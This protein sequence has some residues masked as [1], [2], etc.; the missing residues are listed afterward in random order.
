MYTDIG[1]PRHRLS[2]AFFNTFDMERICID[3]V[4]F[5]VYDQY[6]SRGNHT[7]DT[8]LR[9]RFI[10]NVKNSRIKRGRNEQVL[11]KENKYSSWELKLRGSRT[12]LFHVNVIH[13]LQEIHDIRP[14]GVIYDDNY[15]PV[16]FKKI[17]VLDYIRALRRF[18]S[19]AMDLYRTLVKKYWGVDL[20]NIMYKLTAVELP[21][22]IYPA[23]VEDIA[24]GMYARG[25]SFSKYNTQSGTL[26]LNDVKCDNMMSV[27]R[28]YD[29][30]FKID[31]SEISP[32]V[33]NIVYVNGVNSGKNENKIQIKLYQKTFGLLRIEFTIY[34]DDALSIFNFNE[35]DETIAE[36]L[37]LF[38]HNGLFENDITPTRYDRSLDDIVRFLAVAVKEPED[39]IYFLRNC[40]VFEANRANKDLRARLVH[41]GLLLR[42]TDS[43]GSRQRGIY[44]VNPHVKDFLNMYKPRGNEHFIKGGLF[45]DL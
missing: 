39:M 13:Y 6:Y 27:S 32:H 26:Y 24:T 18:I 37:I 7:F 21:Y 40:D 1:Q 34:S 19:D 25:V 14:T 41:K 44:V 29:K 11:R 28:K 38:I 4:F 43:N 17:T 2:E 42:K 20:D 12:M 5:I 9:D 8:V 3:K 45:P 15:L 23:S 33:P 36:T 30:E 16:D 35:S 22:E 10:Q 31:S